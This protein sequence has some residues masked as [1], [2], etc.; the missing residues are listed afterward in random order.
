MVNK[1]NGCVFLKM[2]LRKGML[3]GKGGFGAMLKGSQAGRK[4]TN[5]ESCRDLNGRRLRSVNN[6]RRLAEW[7]KEREEREREGKRSKRV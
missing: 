2:R 4:T 5:F 6:E 1:I 3:G 7:R